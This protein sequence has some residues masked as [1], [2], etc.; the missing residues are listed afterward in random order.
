MSRKDELVASGLHTSTA[1]AI[2]GS[3][4]TGITAAGSTQA[5][6]TALTASVNVVSTTAAST[7]VQ[8]PNCQV[9][10]SVEVYNQGANS[11]S[12]YPLTG[13]NINALSAN[14]AFAVA[15]GKAATFRKVSALVWMSQLCA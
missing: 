7:G 14:A 1:S 9:G 11:L 15:A 6:A 12:V 4:T 2:T 3:I 10:D 13:E 8:L 5:T